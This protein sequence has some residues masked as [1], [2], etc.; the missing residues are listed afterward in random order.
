VASAAAPAAQAGGSQD[1]NSSARP[2]NSR[3]RW[4]AITP[5][6]YRASSSP[7]LA[8]T[9][10]RMLSSSRPNSST[11][12]GLSRVVVDMILPLSNS[13]STGPAAADAHVWTRSPAS[14][15]T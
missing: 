11:S 7:R 8:I 6:M 1:A 15:W 14:P 4:V 5:R 13:I 12:T 3:R 2:P 9:S 10:S